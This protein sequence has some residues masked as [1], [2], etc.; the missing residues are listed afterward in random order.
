L[1]ILSVAVLSKAM[2][3]LNPEGA[4]VKSDF[5]FKKSQLL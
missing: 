2:T 4:D 1:K 3:P 5:Q